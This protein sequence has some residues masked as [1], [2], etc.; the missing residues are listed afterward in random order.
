MRIKLAGA[1]VGVLALAFAVVAYA[2]PISDTEMTVT[3]SASPSKSGTKKKPRNL[4]VVV[5]M[6]QKTKSGTGQPTTTKGF[7]IVFP[8]EWNIN[9]KKWPKKSRCDDAAATR[10]GSATTCP[11]ASL[12]GTGAT[13]AL[14]ANGAV[15]SDLKVTAAVVKDGDIGFFIDTDFPVPIHQFLPSTLRG[16]TLTIEVPP[17]IRVT[18]AG[19]SGITVLN[20]TLKGSV[21]IKGKKRGLIESTSCKKKKWTVKF[22]NVAVDGTLT[23]NITGKCR[24]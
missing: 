3:G 22:S 2:N 21:R 12:V 19:P 13:T 14:I 4:K 1:L 5:N 6:T 8:R 16:R 15:K 20:N 7:K 11:K 23:Q 24:K 10:A 17:D 9:A 18:A